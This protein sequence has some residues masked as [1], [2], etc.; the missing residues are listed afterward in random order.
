[1]TSARPHRGVMPLQN[2]LVELEKCKGK[3]FDPKVL[4]IFLREKI[5]KL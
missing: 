2:V 5:Y 3:Q 4:E 1:M